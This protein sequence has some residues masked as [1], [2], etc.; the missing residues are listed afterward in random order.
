MWNDVFHGSAMVQKVILTLFC[1]SSFFFLPR[2][3]FV[4]IVNS[5]DE[6]DGTEDAGVAFW[7]VFNYIAKESNVSQAFNSIAHVSLCSDL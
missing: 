1:F 7:R 2:I 5:D 4:F 3:G 6:V